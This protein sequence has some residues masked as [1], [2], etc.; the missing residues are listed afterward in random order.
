MRS[1]RW[2]LV[3]VVLAAAAGGCYESPDVTVH[4]PGVYKGP[5]DPLRAKLADPAFRA[6][7]DQRFD[8]VQRDR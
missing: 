3:L 8:T 7:L 5:H 4:E 1:A 2:R 6:R